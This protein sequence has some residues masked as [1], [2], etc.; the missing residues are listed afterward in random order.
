MARLTGGEA[1]VGQLEREGVDVVFGIPG[2]HTLDVYDALVDSDLE[3]I[4]NRHEQGTGFMADG[5][6]RATGRVGV[7][8][9]ITGPGLTNAATPIGQAYSDSSPM[10]VISS[11][12]ETTELDSGKG[13]L[14]EL[15]DQ[16]GV[17][18]DLAA[19]SRRVDRVDD[20]PGA[21]AEAFEYLETHRPRPVHLEIPRDVLERAEPVELADRAHAGPPEADRD[22]IAEAVDRLHQAERPVLVVGGGAGGA[23]EGIR[24]L[25]DET[26][27]PVVP[28]VG[29]KGVV[30]AS[31]ELNLGARLGR[32]P[33]SEFV[34]SRDL[35]LVVGSEL[36]PRDAGSVEFPEETIHVD[37]DYANF[38]KNQPV[39][40]GIVAD[41]ESAV[42]ALLDELSD[43][44][45]RFDDP[46]G[47][48]AET[49][50]FH[51]V[52]D[53][54]AA[55]DDRTHVLS[56]VRNALDDDAVVVNDQTKICY[57]A[58]AAFPMSEP[59]SFLIPQGFGTLGF[60]PPVAFGAAV[61]AEDRQ[62]VAL[63]GDGG[64]MF[65]V[66]T[67]S[68]AVK[69][70]LPVPVLVMND[71]SYDVIADFQNRDYGGRTIGTELANP[72]FVDMAESFGAAGR[73]L[74]FEDVAD[75]LP[76]AMDA[77]FD[78]DG[79]TLIEVLVDW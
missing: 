70:D 52:T 34:E 18:E 21:I 50:S 12:N 23:S 41:A 36:S 77:A 1:V 43:R 68:T 39:S 19:Y 9:V 64:F 65:T 20:I 74:A 56:V 33:V 3:A 79:P 24:R 4:T 28:T 73:R 16:Q 66:Q 59:D 49:L 47:D 30:P 55:E 72:D 25:V 67:L 75:E 53:P 2:V 58:T 8:L 61:G 35:A 27:I 40:L 46:L 71:D 11:H 15:K 22:R 29:G 7:A 51:P 5:Y 62:V 14:H 10:L 57:S 26:G 32:G 45:V 38:G 54:D 78:R 76:A 69:Y 13:Y 44:P 48:D 6:A 42:D 37:V 63:V 31:H 60:S 17:M